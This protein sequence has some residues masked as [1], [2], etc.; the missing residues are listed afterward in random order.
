[1]LSRSGRAVRLLLL[2]PSPV[3]GPQGQQDRRQRLMRFGS[4]LHASAV[5]FRGW[6]LGRR[7]CADGTGGGMA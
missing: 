2:G 1:L 3:T 5:P 4:L 6:L 7:S